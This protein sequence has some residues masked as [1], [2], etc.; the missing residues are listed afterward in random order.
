MRFGVNVTVYAAVKC[1][2]SALS[3]ALSRGE[4]KRLGF[5]FDLN[6][7]ESFASHCFV[8]IVHQGN[9]TSECYQ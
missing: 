3:T 2:T 7:L 6:F 8:M 5:L 4:S 9:V 1:R